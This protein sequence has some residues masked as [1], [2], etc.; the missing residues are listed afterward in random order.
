MEKILIIK[1]KN[2]KI[3]QKITMTY[4]SLFLLILPLCL[5]VFLS[6]FCCFH[7][8]HTTIISFHNSALILRSISHSQ[9]HHLSTLLS[10]CVG[11]C[12]FP[13]FFFS[14]S[15]YFPPLPLPILSW[16]QILSSKSLFF[17]CCCCAC[18]S[19]P[20]GKSGSCCRTSSLVC[21]VVA[22]N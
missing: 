5:C 16:L 8:S 4:H 2:N 1:K 6:L 20:F 7:T 3:C 18:F 19:F 12:F 21:K 14:L 17:F 9:N 10:V 15:L 11:V 22:L 13:F